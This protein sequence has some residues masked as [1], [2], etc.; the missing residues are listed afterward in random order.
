MNPVVKYSLGRL[1]IF[2]V[3]AVPLL[4]VLP[5]EMN[6]FL[7]LLLAFAISA[8]LG[9]VLLRQWREEVAQRLDSGARRRSEQKERL[10]AALAGEDEGAGATA[11]DTTT[12][13]V[14]PQ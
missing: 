4:L 10:R 11:S 8:V 13:E 6:F 2:V 12:S 3:V 14:S 9:F 1:G 5:R 7:K